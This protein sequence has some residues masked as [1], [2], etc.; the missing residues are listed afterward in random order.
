MTT[1]KVAE[2]LRNNTDIIDGFLKDD[3]DEILELGQDI[4]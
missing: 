3:S 2:L 4:S 1:K